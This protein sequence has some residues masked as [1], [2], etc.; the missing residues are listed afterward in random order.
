MRLSR[1][2]ATPN[3][4]LQVLDISPLRHFTLATSY[5]KASTRAKVE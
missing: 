4:N 3:N 2:R 5:P 1:M